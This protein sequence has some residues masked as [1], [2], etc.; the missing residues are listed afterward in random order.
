MPAPLVTFQ[1]STEVKVQWE[2]QS[3]HHGGPIKRYE[4]RVL[5]ETTKEEYIEKVDGN[6]SFA[7]LRLDQIKNNI[8]PV[9][10]SNITYFYDFFIRSVTYEN[11][12]EF[13]SSWSQV[14]T[15]PGYCPCE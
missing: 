8:A 9:C 14:E 11:S 15:I 6:S 12:K 5:S 7:I 1:N 13:N 10:S 4:V 2:P 3:F